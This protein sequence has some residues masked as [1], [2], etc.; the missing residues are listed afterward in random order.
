MN[1]QHL[2]HLQHLP[3]ASPK[4]FG[5]TTMYIGAYNASVDVEYVEHFFQSK[6]KYFCFQN[7]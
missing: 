3:G 5:F 4:T 2:Q 7:A 1:V 6:R